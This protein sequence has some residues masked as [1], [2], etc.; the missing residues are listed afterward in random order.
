MA[1]EPG[2][3]PLDRVPRDGQLLV[4]GQQRGT[5]EQA[6]PVELGVGEF[7]PVDTPGQAQF[8]EGVQGV[9]VV[10]VQDDVQAERQS[11]GAHQRGRPFLRGEGAPAGDPVR[12]RGVRVLHGQLD[13]A[14]PGR[15]QRVEP[16]LVEP[17][18][19]GDQLRVDPGGFGGGDD[20]LEIGPQQ[21]LA[22]RQVSV[23]DAE[24]TGLA[25]QVLPVTGRQLL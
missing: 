23:H 1:A 8:D 4:G 10:A 12:G 9:Q 2:A 24:V 5:V 7:D 22:A 15:G 6:P 18:A 19:A 14:E 21:R 25:H 16:G 13:A 3:P 17:G 11:G 20:L